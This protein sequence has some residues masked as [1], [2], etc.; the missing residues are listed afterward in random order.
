VADALLSAAPS[1]QPARSR[2]IAAFAAVYLLWGS[3]YLAIRFAIDT[4]PPLAMA[5]VRF[6]VAGAVLYALVRARGAA[7]PTRA[8]WVAALIVGG[9]LL[10]CGNGS[11]VWAEQ[12]VPSGIAAL[13]V[14]TVALWMVLMDWLRPGGRRPGALVIAGIALGLGGLVLL[15][16]PS[17]FG[18]QAVNPVGAATLVVA[19]IAWAA[20]SIYS[21][22]A[23]LPSSPL[24]A[25]AMEMLAG[26]ALLVI[27][28]AL[29]GEVTS[30]DPDAV[31]LRSGLAL[32]Y[33]VIFGSLV[34]FS[35][36]VW[37]LRVASPSSV[38]TYAY[39]NP[40]VAVILGW[41]LAGE[42][43]TIRTILAAGVIVGAVVLITLGRSAKGSG[44][45]HGKGNDRGTTAAENVELDEG[46]TAA[47][48]RG[49]SEKSRIRGAARIR[50]P[51]SHS[52]P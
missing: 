51:R 31:S 6:L 23:K 30:F 41:A 47:N 27:A 14:A 37:L 2:V 12:L 35:A 16:Q 50:Q 39:V 48:L 34:G 21:T 3:T 49:D 1:T 15:V 18:G 45:G 8:N 7:K 29:T 28:G 5:G 38:S 11:V 32:L 24:L 13:L 9:L 25:T 40:V 22:R 52:L 10:A 26:G 19:S 20:G 33:L 46:A 17:S 43:L 42:E 44:G 4:I 36:Y